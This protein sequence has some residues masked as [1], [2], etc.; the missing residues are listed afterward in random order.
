MQ[1]VLALIR[2]TN[3]DTLMSLYINIFTT[4]QK[5]SLTNITLSKNSY[6]YNTIGAGSSD[7]SVSLVLVLNIAPI[8]SVKKD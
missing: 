1:A 3:N 2:Y 5:V 4:Y 8:T 7:V 6:C